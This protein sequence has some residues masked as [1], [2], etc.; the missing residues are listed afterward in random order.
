M[1]IHNSRSHKRGFTLIEL[2]IVISIIALLAAILFP[3]FARA[4]ENARRASCQSNLKQIGLAE[5]QYT[6]D[7][8]GRMTNVYMCRLVQDDLPWGQTNSNLTPTAYYVYW[9]QLLYPYTKSTQVFVCPS[10]WP[11]FKNKPIIGHYGANRSI[12]PL[13]NTGVGAFPGTVT[14]GRLEVEI[15]EP[16]QKYMIADSGNT[17]WATGWW[18]GT[19]V[20]TGADNRYRVIPG[21]GDAGG[22]SCT[23]DD[24]WGDRD[25]QSGRHFGG[26]NI[27]F[28][29]GHVKWLTTKTVGAEAVK[30]TTG[31]FS[32]SS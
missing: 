11:A 5:M 16:A 1:F 30:G 8:D 29:D 18:N 9:P 12:M 4:R 24:N 14:P 10:G 2:L 28:V 31:A 21:R 20:T 7:Y 25:C 6:Q 13:G 22:G 3:V 32:P 26:V 17:D 15:N 27:L 19:Y 23:T